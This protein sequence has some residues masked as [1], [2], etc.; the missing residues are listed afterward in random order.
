LPPLRSLV[1]LPTIEPLPNNERSTVRGG[2]AKNSSPGDHLR[3]QVRPVAL[4]TLQ[5]AAGETLAEI[6]KSYAVDISMI[7]RLS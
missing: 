1:F 6:A 7:S 5:V 3:R 4:E 2:R